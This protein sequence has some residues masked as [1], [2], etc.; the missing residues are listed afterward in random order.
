MKNEQGTM[1]WMLEL[2]E[3]I[4]LAKGKDYTGG[5]GL[6]ANFDEAANDLGV[7]PEMVLM[8]YMH[9]HLKAISTYASQP[10]AKTSEPIHT[11]IADAINYLLLLYLMVHRRHGRYQE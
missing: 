11:R 3:S 9:K 1:D 4:R 2:A 8:I 7:D 5:R 10:F 6:L